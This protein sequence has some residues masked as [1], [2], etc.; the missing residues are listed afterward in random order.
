MFKSINS[1]TLPQKQTKYS[2]GFDVYSNETIEIG[3]NKTILLPLGIK[4][5]FEWIDRNFNIDFYKKHYLGL[6]IRSSLSLKKNLILPNSVG[7]IDIDYPDELKIIL[8]NISEKS[9]F[10]TKKDRV[11]QLILHTHNGQIINKLYSKDIEIKRNGGF[12]ST[13]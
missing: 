2:V 4:I 1:G 12:G 11:G 7:I 5:D 8:Y 3:S 10:I 13:L 6:Y 9:V